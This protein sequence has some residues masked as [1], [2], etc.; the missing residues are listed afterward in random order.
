MQIRKIIYTGPA[1]QRL[2]MTFTLN[3]NAPDS[4][5]FPI[6]GGLVVRTSGNKAKGVTWGVIVHALG[7]VMAVSPELRRDL[8]ALLDS[9][10]SQLPASAT[11]GVLAQVAAEPARI[12]VADLDPSTLVGIAPC[13]DGEEGWVVMAVQ[14]DPNAPT[15]EIVAPVGDQHGQLVYMNILDAAEV[16]RTGKVWRHDMGEDDEGV[17]RM[18][19]ASLGARL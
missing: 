2:N 10:D 19:R 5:V 11:D 17:E 15:M 14:P 3:K 16:L 8:R 1:E 12:H 9:I 13:D 7:E 18:D 6:E 4:E